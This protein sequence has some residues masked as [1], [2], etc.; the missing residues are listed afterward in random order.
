LLEGLLHGQPTSKG[1]KTDSTSLLKKIIII[2]QF[3]ICL[4]KRKQRAVCC[5]II[6]RSLPFFDHHLI[7]L[8]NVS[9]FLW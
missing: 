6:P 8:S 4:Y 3:C 7:V 2:H 5:D 1:W 9:M